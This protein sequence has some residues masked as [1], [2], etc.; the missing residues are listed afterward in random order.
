MLNLT[1]FEYFF[2][3]VVERIFEYY[4]LVLSECVSF[5]LRIE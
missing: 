4:G 5:P 1:F 3:V 2:F